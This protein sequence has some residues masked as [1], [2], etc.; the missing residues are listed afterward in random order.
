MKQETIWW[1]LQS[2]A[3]HSRPITMPAQI[4]Q[5]FTGQMLFMMLN[6]Q[7]QSTEGKMQMQQIQ[8]LHLKS[9]HSQI[10]G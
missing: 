2:S 9:V 1:Q 10:W 8:Y 6:Q 4:T 7:Y 3:P 5:F